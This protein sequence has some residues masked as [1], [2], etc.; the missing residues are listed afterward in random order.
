[1]II[2]YTRVSFNRRKG[3]GEEGIT[4]LSSPVERGQ[5]K[6]GERKS[7]LISPYKGERLG[8]G[9]RYCI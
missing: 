7:L 8:K 2:A 5:K 4:D 9:F 3:K 6:E 1:L